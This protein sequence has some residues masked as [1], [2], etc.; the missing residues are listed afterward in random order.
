MHNNFI[1]RNTDRIKGD[2]LHELCSNFTLF[3][4]GRPR[5]VSYQYM[6][7]ICVTTGYDMSIT[8]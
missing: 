1:Q 6:D 5:F 7:D 3:L 8:S 4:F 2:I